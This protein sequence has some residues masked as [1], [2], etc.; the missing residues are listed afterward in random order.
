LPAGSEDDLSIG[1]R[2]AARGP[3]TRDSRGLR[4]FLPP[5]WAIHA[6]Q[7]GSSMN[8]DATWVPD[9]ACRRFEASR[10]ERQPAYAR[11]SGAPQNTRANPAGRRL[12]L[13]PTN[14]MG[15]AAQKADAANGMC[16]KSGRLL[17]GRTN[18]R[19]NWGG[20]RCSRASARPSNLLQSPAN[21]D[22]HICIRRSLRRWRAGLPSP[23]RSGGTR[24]ARGPL[25]LRFEAGRASP[26][27]TDSDYKGLLRRE[28]H[29][30]AV[31]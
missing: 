1:R 31:A 18:T 13:L 3:P 27:S 25:R 20:G 29:F 28:A 19:P 17:E 24:R 23:E 12:T 10:R 22:Q 15:S 4:R 5:V 8:D 30:F 11:P 2:S 21:N 7:T 14:T 6:H 26:A 9:S 16:A